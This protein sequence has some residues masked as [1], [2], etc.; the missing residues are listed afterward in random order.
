MD[1]TNITHDPI[2]LLFICRVVGRHPHSY[3][4]YR[5]SACQKKWRISSTSI[6]DAYY[7]ASSEIQV[8]GGEGQSFR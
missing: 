8:V 2:E 7:R 3:A 6:H 4:I 1:H 5:S